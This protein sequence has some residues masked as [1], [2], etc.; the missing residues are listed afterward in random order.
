MYECHPTWTFRLERSYSPACGKIL[1]C[2]CNEAALKTQTREKEKGP[3]GVYRTF[4]DGVQ[5][6]FRQAFLWCE[7][8][9]TLTYEALTNMLK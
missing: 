8:I 3:P 9:P 2:L 5:D 1:S 4:C 7:L 6:R